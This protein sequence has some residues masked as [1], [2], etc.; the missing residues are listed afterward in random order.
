[1]CLKATFPFRMEV[2]AGKV[3]VPLLTVSDRQGSQE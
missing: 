3:T 2:G 1:M